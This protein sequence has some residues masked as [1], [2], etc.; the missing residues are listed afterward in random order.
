[1]SGQK[2]D[3]SQAQALQGNL[4]PMSRDEM[5]NAYRGW[6]PVYDWTFGLLTRAG[7]RQAVD[8][9]NRRGGLVLDAGVGTGLSFRQYAPEVA[10]VGVDLSPDMLGFAQ[11]KMRREKPANVVGLVR[12]DAGLLCFADDSFDTVVAMAMLSAT[13]DPVKV[14]D[15]LVRVLRPGGELVLVNHFSH[16]SGWLGWVERAMAPHGARLGWRPQ[17]PMLPFVERSELT[18][19]TSRQVA[20]WGMY[21]LLSFRKNDN[22]AKDQSGQIPKDKTTETSESSQPEPPAEPAAGDPATHQS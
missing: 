1:M 12:N 7:R 19:T 11:A 14:I 16:S 6:A 2:G 17:F 21:S 5:L 22:A 15:E 9:I 18:L 20:P 4:V 8:R 3:L 10:V 13:C